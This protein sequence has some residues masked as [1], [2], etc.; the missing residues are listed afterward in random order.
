MSEIAASTEPAEP[1]IEP[2]AQPNK[3]R[4]ILKGFG[5]IYLIHFGWL[6][7]PFAYLGIGLLQLVYVLPLA[8]H[9]KKLERTEMRQGIWIAAVTTFLLSATCYGL[10]LGNGFRLH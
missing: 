9:Y 8:Q 5:L 6:V 3:V 10:M 7:F 2:P 1:P 4:E